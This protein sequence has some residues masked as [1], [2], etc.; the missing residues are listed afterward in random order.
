[1]RP[2]LTTLS[3]GGAAP[4][5]K[6]A[7]SKGSKPGGAGGAELQ[8]PALRRLRKAGE[9]PRD[10][11]AE[12]AAARSLQDFEDSEDREVSAAHLLAQRFS[13]GKPQGTPGKGLC[14]LLVTL[15]E[16]ACHTCTKLLF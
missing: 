12:R 16:Q 13:P 6:E 3:T 4:A 7:R 10:A 15:P 1:M 5:A 11:V 8:R 14:Q 2:Y 9:S